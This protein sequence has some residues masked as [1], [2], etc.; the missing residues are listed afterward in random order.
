MDRHTSA[1]SMKVE[2][3]SAARLCAAVW[4]SGAI[5]DFGEH[6]LTDVDVSR[7]ESS[8]AIGEIVLPQAAETVIEPKRREVWPCSTE[9]IS[10]SCERL[11]IILHENALAND[12][13]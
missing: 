11:G 13:Y 10:P 8:L 7:Q 6:D 9:V 2:A 5:T 12:R 3:G 1:R 4:S